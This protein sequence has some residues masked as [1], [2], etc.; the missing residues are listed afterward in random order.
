MR[1]DDAKEPN[2][3]SLCR[4]ILNRA[5]SIWNVTMLQVKTG[6]TIALPF[7]SN[8]KRIIQPDPLLL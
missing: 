2:G 6:K 8:G 7:P 4:I 1:R 3:H 5:I